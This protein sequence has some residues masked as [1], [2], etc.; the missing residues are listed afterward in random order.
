[1]GKHIKKWER[2]FDKLKKEKGESGAAAICSS[3]IKNAGIKA[4]FQKRDK[5][6][7]YSNK[8][9]K[10]NDS[11]ITDFKNF[12][13]TFDYNDIE[14]GYGRD[15]FE[16]GDIVSV[17]F[18]NALIISNCYTEDGECGYDLYYR[19]LGGDIFFT[20][21]VDI[22]HSENIDYSDM[23]SYI[24]IANRNN[25]IVNIPNQFIDTFPDAVEIMRKRNLKSKYNI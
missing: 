20:N 6:D 1:M 11:F 13:E 3:S 8:K 24:S 12:N 10:L 23:K 14:P 9:K 25:Y 18:R 17:E 7:Y 4:Q 2:C 19:S 15:T 5:E 16:K 21:K 22:K